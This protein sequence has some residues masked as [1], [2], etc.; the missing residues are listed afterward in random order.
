[1]L[2]ETDRLYVQHWEEKD[3]AEL[4]NLFNDE[5]ILDSVLPHLTMGETKQI[6][7][8][9]LSAYKDEFPFGRYFIKE[10]NGHDFIG[11]LLLKKIEEDGIEIG[12]SFI[13][14]QWQKG[15]AT[16][17][18]EESIKWLCEL[19]RFLHIYA[20]TELKNDK[21]IRVLFKCGFQQENN[22]DHTGEVMNLFS[23][24]F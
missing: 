15:F 21:S 9:Q 7:D 8:L 18:V 14:S 12:Y 20:V 24:H 5:A 3:L 22:I 2:F 17:V 4:Y 13:K 10:K 11:L 6:F 19:N 16:E 23:L 1:M